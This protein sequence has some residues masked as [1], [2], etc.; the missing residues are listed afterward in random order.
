NNFGQ[1]GDGTPVNKHVPV[2]VSGLTGVTAISAGDYHSLAVKGDGTAWAW[3]RNDHGQLGDDDAPIDKLTPVMISYDWDFGAISAGYLH[4]LA[5]RNDGTVWAWGRNYEGQLGDGTMY[6]ERHVPVMVSGLTGVTAISAH[7]GYHSLALRIDTT[8]WAWGMNYGGA[9]GDGTRD[10]KDTPVKVSGLT[11]VTA[12][13]VGGAFH[14]L[15]VKGDGTAWAW[16]LNDNGECGDGTRT[17]RLAPVQVH[18]LGVHTTAAVTF[19]QIGVDTDF[20]GTVLT[21]DGTINLGV[22]DLPKTFTWNIG[23]THTYAYASPL[24]TGLGKQYVL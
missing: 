22:S 8:V 17:M 19:Y 7:G 21:I 15:A 6:N 12:I 1:L 11:G 3:G 23:S 5:L 24:D 13:S 14:S 2:Q 16:G 10:N 9:L 4:S 20:T 18:V